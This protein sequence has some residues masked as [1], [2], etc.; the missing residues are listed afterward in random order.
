MQF[1]KKTLTLA[2]TAAIAL[3][4]TGTANASKTTK[5]QGYVSHGVNIYNGERIADYSNAS[6]IVPWLNPSPLIDEV[7]AYDEANDTAAVITLETNKQSLIATSDTFFNFMNPNGII[8][9]ALINTP[10]GNIG[11]NY[12]GFQ[13]PEDRIIPDAFPMPGSAPSVYYAKRVN[14]TPTVEQWN[15][16]SGLISVREKRNGN[17]KVKVTIKNGLPNGLYTL[18]DV[19]ATNPLTEKEQGY[20]V[21]MGGL[22]NVMVTDAKGCSYTEIEMPYSIVRECKEG[23]QSCSSY[24]N[25]VYHWDQQ[26]YGASPGET[27]LGLPAGVLAANQLTWPTSGDVLLDP[28]TRVP[29]NIHGCY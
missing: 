17:F 15:K 29:F 28:P 1:L 8:D 20:A 12:F 18:W 25:A 14:A 19:G 4:V 11:S 3:S 24:I 16:I 9:P 2:T 13:A 22:P 27:F 7:R 5:I 23:A 10:I 6:P 26:V 21:P